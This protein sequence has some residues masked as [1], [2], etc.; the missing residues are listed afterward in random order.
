MKNQLKTSFLEYLVKQKLITKKQQAD[1]ES[2]LQEEEDNLDRFLIR[3]KI[4]KKDAYYHA[5]SEFLNIPFYL[6][7]EEDLNEEI[8]RLIPESIARK[9]VIIP[10]GQED[11]KLKL[12]MADPS[13]LFVI[14][15]VSRRT[16][17]EIEP[18]LGVRDEILNGLDY[19]FGIDDSWEEVIGDLQGDLLQD[20]EE[21]EDQDVDLAKASKLAQEAPVLRLV[22]NLIL[23]ALKRK[24]SDI[25]IEPLDRQ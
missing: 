21:I 20:I 22:N 12:A 13:N 15:D 17:Y 16:G 3:K 19:V 6:F 2:S 4:L 24:A 23:Q 18:V 7:S 5:L 14:D 25:H 9:H 11:G 10:V 1:V 8:I